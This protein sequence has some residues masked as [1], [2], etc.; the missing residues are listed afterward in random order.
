MEF[1]TSAAP[2]LLASR[3]ISFNDAL[4][5]DR[6]LEPANNPGYHGFLLLVSSLCAGVV[7]H[8]IG[9]PDCGMALS[10]FF[11]C[12]VVFEALASL[13]TKPAGR[14]IASWSALNA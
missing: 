3:S 8:L 11:I 7:Q 4:G 6:V 14:G 12:G 10:V 2:Q 1:G 13:E 9:R 5:L